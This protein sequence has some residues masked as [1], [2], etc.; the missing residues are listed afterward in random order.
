M[1][2]SRL[3]FL[4]PSQK[5]LL[6]KSFL[7]CLPVDNIPDSLEVLRFSILILEAFN[8]SIEEKQKVEQD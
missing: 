2:Q 3:P 8:V 4:C 1:L 7:D 6:R 5:Q